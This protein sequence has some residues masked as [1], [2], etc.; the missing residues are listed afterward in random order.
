MKEYRNWSYKV[1]T[2]EQAEVKG[3]YYVFNYENGVLRRWDKYVK[4][5]LIKKS[6]V[7]LEGESPEDLIEEY[8]DERYFFAI[9]KIT[10]LSVGIKVFTF[11][12]YE[13][14]LIELRERFAVDVHDNY[15]G[16]EII[17][18]PVTGIPDFSQTEKRFYNPSVNPDDC[19]FQCFYNDDDGSL[20]RIEYNSYHT[21]PYGQDG[22]WF[23]DNPESLQAL[24]NLTGISQDLVNYYVSPYIL[25]SSPGV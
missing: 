21:D 2:K 1:I 25:P 20:L 6:Y 12:N 17:F 16:S 19:L 10:E 13:G 9:I 3:N 22:K 5:D 8:Y 14:S 15:V 23:F 24:M 7:L 11:D 4:F 18:D